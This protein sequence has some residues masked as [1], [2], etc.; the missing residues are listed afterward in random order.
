MKYLFL[1]ILTGLLTSCNSVDTQKQEEAR[2]YIKYLSYQVRPVI[3]HT[4]ELISQFLQATKMVVAGEVDQTQ[5]EKL[6]AKLEQVRNLNHQNLKL[7]EEVPVFDAEI[8]LRSVCINFMN[9]CDTLYADEFQKMYETVSREDEMTQT[10]WIAY[11]D[12]VLAV[13]EKL[14]FSE[15]E[16]TKAHDAFIE[17]YQLDVEKLNLNIEEQ[18][19]QYQEIYDRFQEAK[20]NDYAE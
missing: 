16:L 9:Q 19:K 15:G 4:N 17:K 18:L 12:L 1:F 14:L 20:A 13:W 7:V 8:N 2:E 10:S 5:M 3:K 11:G 6:K